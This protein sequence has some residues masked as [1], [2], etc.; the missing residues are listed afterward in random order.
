MATR[1]RTVAWKNSLDGGAWWTIGNGIAK[2]RTQLSNF[3]S[4]IG[5]DPEDESDVSCHKSGYPHNDI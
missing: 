2:D 5:F 1:C 3:T 4:S